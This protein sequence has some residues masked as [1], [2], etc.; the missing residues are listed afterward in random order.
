M[1][2]TM[3]QQLPSSLQCSAGRTGH[4]AASTSPA[5]PGA[6]AVLGPGLTAWS[7]HSL[8]LLNKQKSCFIPGF[9]SLGH[10]SSSNYSSG[11]RA[12]S[13]QTKSSAGQPGD[14]LDPGAKQCKAG[15]LRLKSTLFT[16][17]GVPPGL[18][19]GGRCRQGEP[20]EQSTS[21]SPLEPKYAC[22][23]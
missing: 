20:I 16:T 5:T 4:P 21:V 14:H 10:I 3:S 1:A 18:M 15:P 23:S 11:I 7:I 8:M 19:W 13:C 2:A 17:D 22:L 12:R 6:A 9:L